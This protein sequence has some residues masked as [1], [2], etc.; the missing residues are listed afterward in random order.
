MRCL[1]KDWSLASHYLKIIVLARGA[2]EFSC[3]IFKVNIKLY[4]GLSLAAGKLYDLLYGFLWI[5]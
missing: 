3:C 4:D 1:E 2:D 5:T